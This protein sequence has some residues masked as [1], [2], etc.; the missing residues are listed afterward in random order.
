MNISRKRETY[1]LTDC[2]RWCHQLPVRQK[3]SPRHHL[4]LASNVLPNLEAVEHH[5]LPSMQ[6][7]YENENERFTSYI[8]LCH[9]SNTSLEA[10]LPILLSPRHQKGQK[11]KLIIQFL[12][13]WHVLHVTVILENLIS[14]APV[15]I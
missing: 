12:L 10:S 2:P 15:P 1:K 3:N 7:E 13:A 6:N 4:I 11:I 9:I 5:K 14:C 8:T